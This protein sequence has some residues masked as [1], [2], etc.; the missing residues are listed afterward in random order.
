M[1]L[2]QA[3]SKRLSELLTERNMTQYALFTK[4]G[5]SKGTV[6]NIISC[7]HKALNLRILWELCQ[8]LG[9]TLNEF[10]DSPLFT[11]DNLDP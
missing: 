3:I 6:S 2:N 5:V 7:R 11:Y 1:Q 8:G 9:I 4:S 10:F